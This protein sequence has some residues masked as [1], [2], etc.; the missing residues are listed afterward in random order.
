MS[1]AAAG[2]AVAGFVL[3]EIAVLLALFAV[4]NR[5]DDDDEDGGEGDR[6]DPPGPPPPSGDGEP[7][8]WPEFE[9]EFAA[10][11]RRSSRCVGP[12]R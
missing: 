8:W 12:R 4:I 3:A 2:V 11:V 1:A 9:Q 10:F 7:E 6:R 5:W